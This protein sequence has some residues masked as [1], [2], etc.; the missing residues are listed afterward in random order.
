MRLSRGLQ[1]T[2][3]EDLGVGFFGLLLFGRCVSHQIVEMRRM[4]KA[5]GD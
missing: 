1:Y 5:V 3:I 4:S 2:E